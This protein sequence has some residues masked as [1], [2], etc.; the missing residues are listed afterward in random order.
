MSVIE[1]AAG[2]FDAHAV[3]RGQIVLSAVLAK[4]LMPSIHGHQ[5]RYK[6]RAG[7][8]EQQFVCTQAICL[9]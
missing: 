3:H 5:M 8:I 7:D 2:T 9:E 1:P 6:R 4:T